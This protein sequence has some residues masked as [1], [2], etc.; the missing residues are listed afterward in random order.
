RTRTDDLK[1][2]CGGKAKGMAVAQ[3]HAM[4]VSLT[5]SDTPLPYEPIFGPPVDFTLTYNQR[6]AS[7]PTTMN[8][9]HLG[10]KWLHNWM[11]FVDESFEQI[12]PSSPGD[13]TRDPPVPAGPLIEV[14]AVTIALPG[15]GSEP[16]GTSESFIAGSPP[17]TFALACE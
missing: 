7:Q 10:P 1:I 8:F 12:M 3:V 15:G 13:V 17:S 5:I 6:E 9:S 11:A 4:T 16:Y 2:G 14:I